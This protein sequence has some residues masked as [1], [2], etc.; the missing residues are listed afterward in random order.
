MRISTWNINGLRAGVRAGFEDWLATTKNDVVCLQEVK[1]QEDLLTASWF[2]GYETHWNPA[3]RPGY[4]G[5]ATMIAL[6]HDTVKVETGI[7]DDVTDKEGRVLLTEFPAFLL[8]NAYAPHSHRLLTRLEQKRSF[9][10]HFRD[11]LGKLRDKGKPIIVAGDL[12]V[13]HQDIDLSNPKGNRKNAGFLPEER[14]WF[15]S[16]LSTGLV[17]AFR[18]FES[19]GGHYTWWSMRSGVR[20]RNVGWRLDYVL[21]DEALKSR[22]RS[23]VHLTNQHGSDHCPVTAEIDI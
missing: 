17:D 13:A 5:A 19:G 2:S 23:C 21:V 7:G 22:V 6:P 11:Y 16:L 12:N 4:S 14:D 1:T 18:I 9:C 20:E 15:D 10:R 8:V 3:R